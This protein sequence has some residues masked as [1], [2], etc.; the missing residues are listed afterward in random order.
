MSD[1]FLAFIKAEI[2]K[3]FNHVVG[4]ILAEKDALKCHTLCNSYIGG[5]GDLWSLFQSTSLL[6]ISLH[7]AHIIYSARDNFAQ[8][9]M[10]EI[11]EEYSKKQQS[12]KK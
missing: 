8:C 5:L 2:Q 9:G 10:H 7:K 12:F 4:L 11:E 1:P 3:G 6:L